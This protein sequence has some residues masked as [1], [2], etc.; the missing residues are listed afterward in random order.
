MNKRTKIV[1]AAALLFV[2]L[3]TGVSAESKGLRLGLEF[4]NPAAVIIIRPSP[5]DFK[6]GYNFLPG[7]EYLFVSGDYRII[8]GYQLVDFLHFFVI[9]Q[10][11]LIFINS[12]ACFKAV[13]LF[14]SPDNILEISTIRLFLLSSS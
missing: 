14:K 11:S 7:S 6:I 13:S 2:V 9:C 8:S 3:V 5:L 4:G 10:L 12:S 1:L